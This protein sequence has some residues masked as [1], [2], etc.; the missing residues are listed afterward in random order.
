MRLG[1]NGTRLPGGED[2]ILMLT[3]ATFSLS[4]LLH[5]WVLHLQQLRLPCVV[6]ALDAA[7]MR[8][9]EELGVHYIDSGGKRSCPRSFV[10][11]AASSP[12]RASHP[13]LAHA[14]SDALPRTAY[15][16]VARLP[17]C[18]PPCVL[19]YAPPPVRPPATAHPEY[20]RTQLTPP[21]LSFER[22]ATAAQETPSM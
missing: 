7:V 10:H 15:K 11:P 2:E 9:S 18:P 4:E 22:H 20:D 21:A 3:F 17:P 12:H 19:S 1:V 16:Q 8:Q 6:A 14:R 13:R 5:N